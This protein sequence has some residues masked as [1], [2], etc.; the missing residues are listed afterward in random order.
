MPYIVKMTYTYPQ[1]IVF[2]PGERMRFPVPL[3]VKKLR[4][5]FVEQ[6]KILSS[7]G[8]F[9]SDTYTGTTITVFASPEACVEWTSNPIVIEF[10]RERDEFLS[11]HGIVK[12]KEQTES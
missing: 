12:V 1:N 3:E 5:T 9:T 4:E 2:P 11:T 6:N 7:D 8:Y 10:F